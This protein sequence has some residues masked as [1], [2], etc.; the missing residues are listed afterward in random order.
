VLVSAEEWQRPEELASAEATA[1]WWRDVA[2]RADS[3]EEPGEGEKGPGL[4][5]AGFRRRFAHLFGDV[6]AV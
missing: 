1:W 2:G 5:E 4:D 3:G 6:G